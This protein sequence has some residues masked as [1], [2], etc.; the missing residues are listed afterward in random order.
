M[1]QILLIAITAGFLASCSNGGSSKTQLVAKESSK[2]VSSSAIK[3]LQ[4]EVKK[5]TKSTEIISLNQYPD[6][7][8][9][10]NPQADVQKSIR[11]MLAGGGT[12]VYDPNNG[13]GSDIGFYIADLTP[14]QINDADFLS[15]LNLKSAMLNRNFSSGLKSPENSRLDFPEDSAN[16][17]PVES[18]G[19]FDLAPQDKQVSLG[20]DTVVAVIDTGI[21]ASHPAFNGR[22]DYWFDAT[23][24]TKTKLLKLVVGENAIVDFNSAKLPE[25][26]KTEDIKIPEIEKKDLATASLYVALISESNFYAQLSEADKRAKGYLDINYNGEKDQFLVFGFKDDKGLRLYVDTDMDLDFNDEAV[27]VDYNTTTQETRDMGMVNFRSRTNI[28]KY[29]ML[30][31][32]SGEDTYINLGVTSG[33]HGTHVAGIIAANDPKSKLIGAAPAARLMSFKVCSGFSC[34]DAAIIKALHNAFYNGQIIPDVI[35][36][37]LGSMEGYR[38]AVYT[39]LMNDLSSKFGTVIFISASNSGPGFRSLNSLGNS[40]AVVMVGANVSKETLAQQYN[41]PD[42]AEA[43]DQNLLFFSSLGPSYTGEMKP[44]IIAPGGAVSATTAQA[45]YSMQFNGTSMSSPLAAGTMAA[46]IGEVKKENANLFNTVTE[47]RALNLE[48]TTR[49]TKTL[50]PHSMALRDSLMQS[51]VEVADL[52]R[53]QQGYGLIQAGGAKS[54]L[55]EYLTEIEAGNRDYFEVVLNNSGRGYDRTGSIKEVQTYALSVGNDG[56]RLKESKASI[57]GVSVF[58]ERVEIMN[59]LGEVTVVE[60]S[61][62]LKYFSIVDAGDEDNELTQTYVR[63]VN[64]RTPSF[65]SKRNIKAYKKG[66]AYL[67]HYKVMH[68]NANVTNIL[69]VVHQPYN[70][71]KVDGLSLPY[72]TK[73]KSIDKALV[74][75]NVSIPVNTFHRYMVNVTDDI[76][77][78]KIDVGIPGKATGRLY[79]QVYNSDGVEA[80]FQVAQKSTLHATR[81]ASFTVPTNKAFGGATNTGLWEITIST[82]SSAWLGKSKYDLIVSALDFGFKPGIDVKIKSGSSKTLEYKTNG[83]SS[84]L[85]LVPKREVVIESVEVKS[86]HMSFHPLPQ[87]QG[88]SSFNVEIETQTL[89]T[90]SFWG[91]VDHRLFEKS[92]AGD[93]VEYAGVYNNAGRRFSSIATSD[94]IIYFAIDTITNYDIEGSLSKRGNPSI[95]VMLGYMLSQKKMNASVSSQRLEKSRLATIKSATDYKP[96]KFSVDKEV[97]IELDLVLVTNIGDTITDVNGDSV[98]IA[99]GVSSTQ[100]I[101]MGP[102]SAE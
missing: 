34:T 95:D 71:K 65:A 51:A 94:K 38:R 97:Y 21:D 13:E 41:L 20:E 40:G 26:I 76:K 52:T 45:D 84:D 58:L 59:S 80:S 92:A 78:L 83:V 9:I 11:N 24:E 32:K 6:L 55:T 27:V 19:L 102:Y 77:N 16:F 75:R 4:N 53:A 89:P 23:E 73:A 96:T 15:K 62:A 98:T 43:A 88:E 87:P 37:S 33:S 70:L 14:D 99:E 44:N 57:S 30:I 25:G 12:L 28:N 46:V 93:F 39:D 49:A 67:A 68:E 31:T 100:K 42:G 7:T 29:P 47:M 17:I 35:N 18:V 90:S 1:K 2:A 50:Y 66:H 85:K 5:A 79:V 60:G 22:V 10:L 82:S 61:E 91:R 69:D 72:L 8:V 56:E 86:Q 81:M 63:F 54:L 48:G 64:R 36:I 74:K 101:M 3:S